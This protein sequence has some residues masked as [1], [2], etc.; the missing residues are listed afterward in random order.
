[1]A[2]SVNINDFLKHHYGADVCNGEVW[3]SILG[4]DWI[5]KYYIEKRRL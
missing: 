5:L 4:N 2:L 3:C 1:M